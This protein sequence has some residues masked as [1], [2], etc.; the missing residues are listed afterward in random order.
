MEKRYIRKDGIPVWVNLTA[1]LKRDEKGTPEHF[2]AVI[3]DISARKLAEVE[4]HHQQ[5]LLGTIVDALPINI[6]LKDEAGRY[7]M[8]NEQV[9]KTTGIAKAEAIGKSDFDLFPHSIADK[10]RSEDHLAYLAN[11]ET[12]MEDV[13]VSHGQERTMLA[14]RKALHVDH[15]PSALL[16]FAIDITERKRSEKRAEHLAT[17]D[18]LTQLPNRSLLH[19]RLAH[20]IAHASRSGRMI[21]VMFLD[22]DRFKLINDSLGH[23]AGDS[24]LVAIAQR[25]KCAVREGD[26]VA[27]QGGDEFVVVLEEITGTEDATRIAE[28]IIRAVSQ[29][30]SLSGHDLTVST[31]VGISLYPKDEQDPDTL[32]KDA[33]TAMYLA[34]ELGGNTFQFFDKAMN[35]QVLG[36][37]LIENGLRQA[38]EKGEFVLHYQPIVDL[39]SGR[40]QAVEALVRW[41]HPEKGLIL[42]LEFI[43]IAE[44]TGQII[45]IGS[46]VL[47]KACQQCRQWQEMGLPKV[48][49]SVNLSVQQLV[50]PGL[51]GTIGAVLKETGLEPGLLELE[52]TETELMQ[53]VGRAVNTLH[54][55]SATGVTLAIDDFGTGYSSLSYLKALPIHT[56][57]IDRSFVRDVV[58]DGNDAAIVS[59]TIAMAH[60]MGLRVIAEGVQTAQQLGFLQQHQCDEAQGYFFSSPITAEAMGQRLRERH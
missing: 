8:F 34:K 59:A 38:L 52:I 16:G 2:I 35:A 5:E 47:R 41:T 21:A 33:D 36:R 51:A 39:R 4:L 48:R 50:S 12:L 49:M 45:K 46:W 24:L 32:L 40:V 44:E 27:R 31:S 30:V 23:T 42:P 37:L 43:P 19:D 13:I 26:T 29:P 53:D 55:L 57:K 18:S 20:A 1:S 9:A 56:L 6:Y 54:E 15:M 60:N 25:L 28:Q 14:G 17:H 10:I 7:L 3:E 58:E 22:L 11:E